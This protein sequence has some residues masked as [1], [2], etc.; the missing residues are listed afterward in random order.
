MCM[1]SYIQTVQRG[2]HE[3]LCLV[4][5]LFPSDSLSREKPFLL[6]ILPVVISR[7]LIVHATFISPIINFKH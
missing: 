6:L 4:P 3:N 7:I 1:E 5:P 2:R